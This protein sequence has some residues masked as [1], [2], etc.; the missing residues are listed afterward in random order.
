MLSA[1]SGDPAR[2]ESGSTTSFSVMDRE[3][4]MVTVTKSIN[5][6][7]GSGVIVPGTGILMNNHMDDFVV[8]PGHI[9]SLEPFKRPLSSMSPTIVLDPQGRPFMTLGSPGATRIFPTLA[10]VISHVIDNG[11]SLQE[12]INSPRWFAAASGQVH[13][14][15]RL[16][17]H[18]IDGLKTLGYDVNIRANW[19]P[20]FG[21][22]QGVHFNHNARRLNGGADPRRD[23]QARAF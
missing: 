8:R 4:N 13:V 21:A 3:G 9:Q 17:D 18:T 16:S 15:N 22:V 2:Y 7:F 5:Y 14:E 10:Q 1:T 20:Y 11:M 6:F 19:D 23:G 12:A